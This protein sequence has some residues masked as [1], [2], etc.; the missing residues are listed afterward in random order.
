MVRK[1][2][3]NGSME[4][5]QVESLILISKKRVPV[6]ETFYDVSAAARKLGF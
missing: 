3:L 1:E 4:P 5:V 6:S 2:E